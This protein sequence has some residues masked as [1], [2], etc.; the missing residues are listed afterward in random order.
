MSKLNKVYNDSLQRGQLKFESPYSS[1]YRTLK[2]ELVDANNNTDFSFTSEVFD[3]LFPL[4]AFRVE[5]NEIPNDALTAIRLGQNDLQALETQQNIS[6]DDLKRAVDSMPLVECIMH[7]DAESLLKLRMEQQSGGSNP[8]KSGKSTN[9][10]P[11]SLSTTARSIIFG[12]EK[13]TTTHSSLCK[14]I[15]YLPSELIFSKSGSGPNKKSLF[16]YI[17]NSD[18][19]DKGTRSEILVEI[20]RHHP[21]TINNLG[22]KTILRILNSAVERGAPDIEELVSIGLGKSFYIDRDLPAQLDPESL[23][24]IRN[25]LN[26][27]LCDEA[28]KDF[29]Y[30]SDLSIK[31]NK[32]NDLIALLN[33]HPESIRSLNTDRVLEILNFALMSNQVQMEPLVDAVFKGSIYWSGTFTEPLSNNRLSKLREFLTPI[34]KSKTD[35][36]VIKF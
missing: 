15:K 34:L 4:F 30:N 26:P 27:I 17:N 8:E 14:I 5:V 3:A 7:F 20:L 32:S 1:V 2:D 16:D 22:T 23:K 35:G 36:D 21:D 33:T 11:Y 13:S 19:F 12:S 25:Y 6:R 9:P 18:I 28:L 29:I 24:H 10:D 31:N